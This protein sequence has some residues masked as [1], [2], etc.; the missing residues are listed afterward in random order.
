MWSKTIL[1]KRYF[2]YTVFA[3]LVVLQLTNCNSQTNKDSVIF[4]VDSSKLGEQV[5]I[6][7]GVIFHPPKS[8]EFDSINIH[9]V[10]TD[11]IDSNNDTVNTNVSHFYVDTVL[12]AV[13]IISKVDKNE[14]VLN[15]I[16]TNYNEI[17]NR[18]NEWDTLTS[19]Q[20]FHNDF[21][22]FQIYLQNKSIAYYRLLFESENTNPFLTDYIIPVKSHEKV[23]RQVESSI[24]SISKNF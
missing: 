16:K 14:Q 23:F 15:S 1:L 7:D 21:K 6:S 9:Q 11:F 13:L 12:Q 24:G 5:N 22:I 2:L 20:L 4:R 10:S 17:F 3:P 8:W 19:V 18:N